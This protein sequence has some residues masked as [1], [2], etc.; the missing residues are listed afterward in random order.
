M[1]VRRILVDG[2]DPAL[3]NAG[4]VAMLE[5]CLGRLRERWPHAALHVF[6]DD[7]RRLADVAP[8]AVAAP[9]V[10][11]RMWGGGDDDPEFGREHAAPVRALVG[12]T[13]ALRRHAPAAVATPLSR[14]ELALRRLDKPARGLLA[15]VAAADLLVFGGRGGLSDEFVYETR[16]ICALAALGAEHG[17]PVALMSQGV[18]PLE[19]AAL[20]DAVADAL[21]RATLVAVRESRLGPLILN[22]LGVQP[23]RIVATGDDALAL[24]VPPEGRRRTAGS[25]RLGVS[26]R[27]A[28]YVGGDESQLQFVTDAV[29][30]F[31]ARVG[32]DIAPVPISG[33]LH[34]RDDELLS[35]LLGTPLVDGPPTPRRA[36][37]QA[38]ACRTVV[39]TCYHAG[40][41][42]LAQGVPVVCCA[43]NAYYA[44]KFE[45]LRAQFPEACHVVHLNHAGAEHWLTGAINQAWHTPLDVRDRLV[46]VAGSLARQSAAAYDRL[47]VEVQRGSVR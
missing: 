46:T 16:A 37:T 42:A 9:A 23:H 43:H 4:D 3:R 22:Q 20:R 7:D 21:P 29:L 26:L 32:A 47:A 1:T 30:A 11:R 2:G 35:E 36:I 15:E 17:I 39:T 5:V 6:V 10:A 34:E 38:G 24:A 40:V 28:P 8:D 14:T 18:G 13:R 12:V 25:R 19:Q 41:F 31:C 45:G 27:R 33:Q 44:H